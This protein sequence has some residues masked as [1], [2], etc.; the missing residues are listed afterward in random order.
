MKTEKIFS[1]LFL[2]LFLI[3]C[4]NKQKVKNSFNEFNLIGKVELIDSEEY[5]IVYK[6]GE[7]EK[8]SLISKSK[9]KYDEKGNLIVNLIFN[10]DGSFNSEYTFK[11]DEKGN[12]IEAKHF[13]AGLEANTTFKYDAKENKIEENCYKSDGSLSLRITFKNDEKGN[14]VE[15]NWYYPDGSLYNKYTFKY[16]ERGNK[17]EENVYNPDGNLE[18]KYTLKYDEKGNKIEEIA[19]NPDGS[20]ENKWNYTYEFDNTGNWLKCHTMCNNKIVVIKERKI[21]YY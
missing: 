12:K 13:P 5:T 11:Y 1:T 16:D 9:E 19:Y 17:I 10:T 14:N 21:R 8:D 20:F 3:G 6:F 4:V 15:E 7:V 18:N 2:L